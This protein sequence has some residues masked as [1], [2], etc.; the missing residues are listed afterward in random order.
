MY[1]YVHVRTCAYIRMYVDAAGAFHITYVCRFLLGCSYQPCL[2]VRVWDGSL[3]L[4]WSSLCS[5]F[6]FFFF[7]FFLFFPE[8][9]FVCFANKPLCRVTCMDETVA[10]HTVRVKKQ[11]SVLR[12]Y[13]YY[14][15][16]ASSTYS[17]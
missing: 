2:L 3:A 12:M 16:L 9:L 4:R 14:S 6:F 13:Y 15:V 5:K 7:F 17:G 1:T 10:G 11:V 8:T